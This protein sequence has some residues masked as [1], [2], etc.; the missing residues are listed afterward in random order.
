MVPK[1]GRPG[2]RERISL[3]NRLLLYKLKSSAL[4]DN[5]MGVKWLGNSGTHDEGDLP[6][7]DLMMDTRS[8]STHWPSCL[9]T[10]P[11]G[12]RRWLASS[13][14]SIDDADSSDDAIQ[15]ARGISEVIGARDVIALEHRLGLV[16]GETHRYA[17]GHAGPHQVPH[18]R[19]T[20]VVEQPPGAA[21]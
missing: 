20:Q 10:P 21:R 5:L 2:R 8:W 9:Q 19:P 3:H 11:R 14:R 6:F 13:R 16:A 1:P 12:L 15:P 17:P 7:D 4:A 18:G